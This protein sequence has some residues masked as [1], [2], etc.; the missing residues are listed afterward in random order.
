MVWNQLAKRNILKVTIGGR[1]VQAEK[2]QLNLDGERGWIRPNSA[3]SEQSPSEIT[4]NFVVGIDLEQFGMLK[5]DSANVPYVEN[6]I[7]LIWASGE[8]Q[9]GG[10]V[11][12]DTPSLVW[13]NFTPFLR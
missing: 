1:I 12:F 4:S 11:E 10:G 9:Q 5:V 6:P 3:W 8:S 7:D 13:S 2:S